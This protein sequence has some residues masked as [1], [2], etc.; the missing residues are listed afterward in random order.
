[1]AS[2]GARMAKV[3]YDQLK[4][5]GRGACV[6]GEQARVILFVPCEFLESQRKQVSV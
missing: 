2:G 4:A 5:D 1:V 3:V 6:S